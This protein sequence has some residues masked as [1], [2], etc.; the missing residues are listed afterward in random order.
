MVSMVT[1]IKEIYS[2]RFAGVP[3]IVKSPGRLNIIGEHTDYNNGFV[4][5]GAIDKAALLAISLRD[6][7]EIHLYAQDL[8]ESFTISID[9]LRPIYDISW[10]NFILGA[11]AQFQKR[12]IQIQGFNAVLMSDVPLGAG[13]SS[14]AAIECAVVF[15]LNELLETK[16]SKIEMVKMAQTAE[17]DYVGVQCGIM[18]QFA[19]MMGKKDHVIKLDCKTLDYE[20][21]PFKLDGYKIVLFNTNVKH[22]L[23]SSEYNIRRQECNTGV[24]LIKQSGEDVQ[25]L[26]DVS[27]EML[28]KYVLPKDQNV[29]YKC[30]Y[31]VEEL[32]RLQSACIDLNNNDL[33]SLGDKMF[34]THDGL[35]NL[36]QVSCKE[37]DW[38][39]NYV[40]DKKAVIGARMMGGGFGGCT[41]NIVREDSLDELAQGIVPAYEAA[42]GL[43][44]STYMSTIEHG[45]EIV[46]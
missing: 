23:A 14:S 32:Q 1:L 40:R 37:L 24:D 33:I 19:S 25:S 16:I 39:V 4:L 31:V 5:P 22:S 11:V 15:A 13:L 46:I 9:N 29:Y 27:K 38:L 8:T 3:L 42:N 34:K 10:P 35:S 30:L 21:V 2:S 18:D 20:Y 6:D 44:L 43:P 28:V 41:I 7:K 12:G 17:H 26:R 45:T 36:Y